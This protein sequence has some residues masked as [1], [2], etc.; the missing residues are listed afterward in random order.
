MAT[1]REAWNTVDTATFIDDLALSLNTQQQIHVKIA[2]GAEASAE[3]GL[4]IYEEKRN[5]L[6]YNAGI[7]NQITLDDE[8]LEE[9]EA[10][11]GPKQ[12]Q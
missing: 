1:S 5:I 6:K 2:S 12:H 11:Y 7:S 4:N 8:T 9:A 3:L 10:I